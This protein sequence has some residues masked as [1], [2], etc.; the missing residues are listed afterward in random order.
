MDQDNIVSLLCFQ[1]VVTKMIGSRAKLRESR[2]L[3]EYHL[4]VS[5]VEGSV[6]ANAFFT[7]T[8][9]IIYIIFN[10]FRSECRSKYRVMFANFISC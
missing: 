5:S 8:N 3:F 6:Y 7:R 9:A 10:S 4:R 1:L 2:V